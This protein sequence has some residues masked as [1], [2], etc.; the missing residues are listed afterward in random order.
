MVFL[1]GYYSEDIS[2]FYDIK[3]C[4][5]KKMKE[6]NSEKGCRLQN[7]A[8]RLEGCFPNNLPKIPTRTIKR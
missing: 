2:D 6:K 3:S 4:T 1:F 8:M 7:Q 5:G